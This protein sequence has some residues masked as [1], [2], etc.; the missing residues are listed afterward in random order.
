VNYYFIDYACSLK[1][2]L[3]KSWN[4]GS[5]VHG[6]SAHSDF[7][8]SKNNLCCLVIDTKKFH[9]NFTKY[10]VDKLTG[11]QV[12]VD[13]RFSV[14]VIA[15]SFMLKRTAS[16]IR[17][18]IHQLPTQI[19]RNNAFAT[20]HQRVQQTKSLTSKVPRNTQAIRILHSSAPVLSE[21]E[22]G[23]NPPPPP[24]KRRW[25]VKSV[26]FLSATGVLLFVADLVIND[27]LDSIPELFRTRL[28]DEERA[29][30]PK[31]VIL[32]AGWA[33]LSM[34]RKLQTD[35]FN[36]TV[37]SPRNYFLFTPLLASTTTGTVEL[38]GMH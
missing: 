22:H 29:D 33:A 28:S 6:N 25:F 30:R 3:F 18:Q 15:I 14:L 4:P 5:S 16:G 8:H 19:I 2:K 13:V 10:P 27:D 17:A 7:G 1:V 9:I 12:F 36:V 35:K 31:I 37:I 23:T 21:P 11:R 26:L 32:G 20:L 34:L 24:N 38:V